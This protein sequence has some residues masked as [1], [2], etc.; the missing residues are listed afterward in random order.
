LIL[1]V[2][3]LWNTRYMN[4]VIDHLTAQ[5]AMISDEDKVRLAPFVHRHLNLIGRYLYALP[6]DIHHG[7]LRPFRAPSDADD[8]LFDLEDL[9]GL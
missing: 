5:G 1:N 8:S 7:A 2:V 9:D 6:V 4:A 3:V